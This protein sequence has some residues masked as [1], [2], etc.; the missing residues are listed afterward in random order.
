M[1]AVGMLYQDGSSN[2][3]SVSRGYMSEDGARA[4]RSQGHIL[5]SVST[6]AEDNRKLE[7]TGHMRSAVETAPEKY[8]SAT[9]LAR[10]KLAREALS[11]LSRQ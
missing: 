9:V 1:Y 5:F 7:E 10:P 2:R 3:D 11:A 4:T 8:E 6:R